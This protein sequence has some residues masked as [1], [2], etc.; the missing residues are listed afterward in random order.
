[1]VTPALI[2]VTGAV[3]FAAPGPIMADAPTADGGGAPATLQAPLVAVG[4]AVVA[5]H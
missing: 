3:V 2:V 1:M 4:P 5:E